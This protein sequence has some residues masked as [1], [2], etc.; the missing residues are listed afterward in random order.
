M[1]EGHSLISGRVVIVGGGV[2]GLEALIG[3]RALAG[4][5]VAVTV[6]PTALQAPGATI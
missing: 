2:A 4:D 6:L 5:R 1:S 3:L